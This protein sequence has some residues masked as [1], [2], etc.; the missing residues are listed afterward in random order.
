[1]QLFG[2]GCSKTAMTVRKAAV[3]R[4]RDTSRPALAGRG[5]TV[6]LTPRQA[7]VLELAA[8]GLGDKEIAA[9]LGIS[10]RTV[11]DRFAEMR[12]RTGTRTRA[13]LVARAAEAGLV[14]PAPGIFPGSKAGPGRSKGPGQR[15]N[16]GNRP[17][18]NI[19][20]GSGQDHAGARAAVYE[21][22]VENPECPLTRPAPL[23]VQ[24]PAVTILPPR[25]ETPPG[26]WPDTLPGALVGYA[27]VSAAGQNPGRQIRALKDTGC[28]RVFADRQSGK[29]AARPELE[30][31][32]DYLRPGDILVVP[33]LDRL[34]RSLQDL[35]TLVAGLRRRDL[36]FRSL[37]EDL[38]TTTPGGR[39]VFHVFTALAEFIRELTVQGTHEGI[40]AAR[41][42][43][44]RLG[45]PPA[46]TPEQIRHARAL[47]AQPD[48]TVSSI[49]R[50]L[51][52]SRAT[53]Y[54]Y[55]PEL[56]TAPQPSITAP[57]ST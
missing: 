21:K 46:M 19:P 24:S 52:V 7:E 20:R 47:L 54:K 26:P 40:V 5:G 25:S 45:R 35:I 12:E 53:I 10:R 8:R 17:V 18:S 6:H 50:L 56:A 51:S 41:A 55:V 37:H 1:L 22:G 30:A 33:S 4:K 23:S 9:Y 13:G 48:N 28:I 15:C 11:E 36:G 2:Q 3:A 32:L 31:C 57:G 42:R 44:A 29:T 39:L 27:R 14:Q 43:G 16:P 34:S 49:A 38:D